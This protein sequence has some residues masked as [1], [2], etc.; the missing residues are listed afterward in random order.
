MKGSMDMVQVLGL[1]AG[2]CTSTAALPQL[3]KAWKT[4]EVKDVSAKMFILYVLGNSLWL[5]Y[6][7]IRSDMPIVVTNAIA[8]TFQGM[9]LFLKIKYRNNTGATNASTI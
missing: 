6:G 9:M 3:V 7:L 2:A 4:K 1:V 8:V 5:I